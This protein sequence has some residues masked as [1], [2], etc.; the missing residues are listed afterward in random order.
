MAYTF[1][2]QKQYHKFDL[3]DIGPEENFFTPNR[4]RLSHCIH[5]LRE[6]KGEWLDRG[7]GKSTAI[8]HMINWEIDDGPPGKEFLI[9]CNS[10]LECDML[11]NYVRRLYIFFHHPHKASCLDPNRGFIAT[12]RGQIFHFLSTAQTNTQSLTNRKYQKVW[13]DINF[14]SLKTNSY[15]NMFHYQR[16]P[17]TENFDS[18]A[19][20]LVECVQRFEQQNAKVF[21]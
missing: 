20:N 5:M 7:E 16:E 18:I 1:D 17:V 8:A 9:L 6:K 3:D 14:S 15:R 4:E 21:I 13:G 10:N 2:L 12:E 19:S 11:I